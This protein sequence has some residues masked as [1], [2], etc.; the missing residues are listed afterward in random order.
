[1]TGSTSPATLPGA[2]R[3]IAPW[4]ILAALCFAAGAW[5]KGS[6]HDYYEVLSKAA[7]LL[8]LGAG[9][10]SVLLVRDQLRA[11]EQQLKENHQQLMEDHKWKT[12]V[13]YHQL[14]A[15]GIPVEPL[16]K[17][18]YDMATDMKFIG[19]FDDLG[20]P[21]PEDIFQECLKDSNMI[22][23][24]R[25]YLDAFEEFSGAV[26]AGIVNESYAMSLQYT[27]VVRNFTV[28]ERL[29]RHF[30]QCNGRAYKE[31]EKLSTKW[32]LMRRA[33]EASHLQNFGV[34]ADK[35]T[36]V[37]APSHGHH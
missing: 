12:I 29:I 14:F 31:F 32:S 22:Q 37:A 7:E 10:F 25:P 18:V 5:T 30:Q 36:R 23:H 17:G 35:S 6:E 33:E 24:I 3:W 28:F 1:M 15:H 27:R 26:N 16:R 8:V 34:G 4:F 9:L 11:Q 20:K 19:C 21:M 13:S 2:T